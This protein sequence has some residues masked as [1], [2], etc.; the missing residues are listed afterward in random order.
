M[1]RRPPDRLAEIVGAAL[2]VFAAR[3]YRRTQMADVAR[4]MGVAPGTLYNYVISKEAL[5]Y[6][7]VDR[8]FVEAPA[9]EPLAVPIP[10][11]A[12]GAILERLR[13]RLRAEAALP[14][15]AAALGRRRPVEARVE[16]EGIVRELYTL[17]E[18]TREGIIVLERSA[19]EWPELARVF[20]VE[21][22]RSLVG[23]LERYLTARIRQ[24]R[25][26]AV[27]SPVATARLLLENVATFAMH[28][29]HDPDPT[30]IDDVTACDTVVDL[31]V[32][33]LVPARSP[34]RRPGKE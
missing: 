28:R 11:P 13:G 19:P 8:A 27:P 15:L 25:L 32:N 16:L 7:V 12:S 2:R 9:A 1:R 6:L 18:R 23:R 34:G 5:F 26:R 20:Y 33:A 4:E 29:Q 21:M 30:P 14:R 17:V 24:R 3:G 31:I 10:T 22:R